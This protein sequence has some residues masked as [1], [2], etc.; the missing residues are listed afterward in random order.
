MHPEYRCLAELREKRKPDP[1]AIDCSGEALFF[2]NSK[3]R[4]LLKDNVIV[5]FEGR[6][7]PRSATAIQSIERFTVIVSSH[8]DFILAYSARKTGSKRRPAVFLVSDRLDCI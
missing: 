5:A 7:R 4:V 6:R 3:A 1:L 8:F 2:R